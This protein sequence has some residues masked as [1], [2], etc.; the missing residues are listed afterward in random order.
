[1]TRA[2]PAFLRAIGLAAS[3]AFAAL[4]L[5]SVLS[6]C[7]KSVPPRPEIRNPG[8]LNGLIR[9]ID[10]VDRIELART[11]SAA[12]PIPFPPEACDSLKRLIRNAHP[13]D[14]FTLTHP[15]WP[16]VIRLSTPERG[17]YAVM[18]VG[19][20]NLR[21]VPDSA[22]GAKADG[23]PYIPPPEMELR[24]STGW[25]WGFLESRLGRT[26]QKDYLE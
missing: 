15:A 22:A 16:A 7:G 11:D 18:L 26:R 10:E 13:M 1:M 6:A 2:T 17:S 19:A 5:L 21:L 12:A 24:D 14:A 8:G 4:A 25:L 3:W 23:A 9:S 20:R